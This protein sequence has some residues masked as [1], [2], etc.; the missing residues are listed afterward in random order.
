MGTFP[1][2]PALVDPAAKLGNYTVVATNGT[3]TI[4][5]A[6]PPVTLTIQTGLLSAQL[7]AVV[8]SAGTILPSGTVQ[9]SEAGANLG[10]AV[11]LTSTAG[12]AQASASVSLT[13]GQHTITATY[14]G[15]ATYTLA[16]STSVTVVISQ[17][18]F[19]F[20]GAG[21]NTS[22]TVAA[23]Q[24]ANYN[25]SLSSQGFSGAVTLTCSGAPAGTT[26][27]V[28]PTSVN[29]TAASGNV[30][31]TVTVATTLSARLKSA[32]VSPFK[33]TLFVFAGV[34]VGLASRARKQRKHLALALLAFSVLGGLTACGGSP[35]AP[36]GPTVRPPTSA[37]LTLTGTSGA[38][39]AS[40]NL[41]LTITH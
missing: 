25:V 39:T 2:V 28:N 30:P 16:T 13:A 11:A 3:L 22:A 18:Q 29:L 31:V 38:Q 1:I 19:V 8:Q 32:P 14:S 24:T 10:A 23:G 37:T 33:T 17:P 26:C 41:S 4:T 34:L 6:T 35:S 20:S 5:K 27:T 36:P 9:F 40:V 7:V 21:G 15:D 12:A